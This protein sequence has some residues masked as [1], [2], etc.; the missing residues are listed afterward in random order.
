MKKKHT[1]LKIIKPNTVK[2]ESMKIDLG[3]IMDH[4]IY[5]CFKNLY[6]F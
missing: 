1:F 6:M 4:Y 3:D 2:N 5:V